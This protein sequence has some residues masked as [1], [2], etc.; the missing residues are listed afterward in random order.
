LWESK[1]ISI[2][3]YTRMYEFEWPTQ[4]SDSRSYQL[5]SL[6]R[7][8]INTWKKINLR[9][10]RRGKEIILRYYQWK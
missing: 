3:G 10:A 1:S 4:K 6:K 7:V 8:R 9:F 2:I 5:K